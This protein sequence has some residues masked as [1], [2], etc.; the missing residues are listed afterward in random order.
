MEVLLLFVTL[1]GVLFYIIHILL[2]QV[3]VVFLNIFDLMSEEDVFIALSNRALTNLNI[4][5]VRTRRIQTS[6]ENRVNTPRS[7]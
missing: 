7:Q 2:S 6:S 5:A 3:L 4:E 1:G